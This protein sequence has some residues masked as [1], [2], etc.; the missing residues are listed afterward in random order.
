[1]RH[2]P[3][4]TEWRQQEFIALVKRNG[5]V[6]MGAAVEFCRD[7]ARARVRV[8]TG[9]L[10]D[11]IIG[12]VE[13]TPDSVTGFVGVKKATFWGWFVERGTKSQPARPFLRPAVFENAAQI[14]RIIRGGR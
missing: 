4:I 9:K 6:N 8:R 13:E 12:V 5:A 7:Q 1:M 2:K 10:R 3:I 14:L 11:N